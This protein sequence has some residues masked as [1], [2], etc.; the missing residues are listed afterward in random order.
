MSMTA[1]ERAEELAKA[2]EADISDRRGLKWEWGKID[3]DVRVT[4]RSDWAALLLTA[5]RAHVAELE[6]ERDKAQLDLEVLRLAHKQLWQIASEMVKDRT[7]R[8]EA[9][10]R[11]AADLRANVAGVTRSLKEY[12]D[13]E[14]Q[15]RKRAESTLRQ[16]REREDMTQRV[17]WKMVEAY[18]DATGETDRPEWLRD[19]L[20]PAPSME[21]SKTGEEK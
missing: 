12:G 6:R 21:E 4:I 2:L 8:A 19:A 10:E 9:A 5:L 7:S 1:E 16:S 3:D 13:K 15:L 11:D 17:L 20:T 18:E 14:R